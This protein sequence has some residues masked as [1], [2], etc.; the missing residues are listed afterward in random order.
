MGMGIKA[1][2]LVRFVIVTQNPKKRISHFIYQVGDI[3]IKLI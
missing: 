3:Y 2:I 1:N